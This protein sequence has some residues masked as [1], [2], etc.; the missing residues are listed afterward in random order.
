MAK[1]GDFLS[2]MIRRGF[3]WSMTALAIGLSALRLSCARLHGQRGRGMP[4]VSPGFGKTDKTSV[5]GVS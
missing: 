4:E 1:S 5:S 2:H 3:R